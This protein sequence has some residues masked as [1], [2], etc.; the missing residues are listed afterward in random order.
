MVQSDAKTAGWKVDESGMEGKTEQELAQKHREDLQRLQGFRLLDD[1]FMGK[2]F[3]DKDC[4]QLLLQII[5]DRDDLTVQSA[6]GQHEIK[7]LQGRSVRL[8]I[9]AVD[10]AGRIY[11]IE[12][13]R[14]DR[15]AGVKRARYNSSLIDANITAPGDGYEKLNETYV[16]FITER[17]VLQAGLPIYH[18]ERTVRETGA[19]FGDGAH[20]IY[21]NSQIKNATRLGKLM[22]D[23]SCTSAGDMYY[24]I[25]AD[26]VR[27]FKENGKG[28]A[29]MCK[30][31][32]D[33]RSEAARE[34][35]H[36]RSVEN[37]RRMLASGKLTDADIA[38]FSG[39]TLE[40]VKALAKDKTA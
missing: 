33:M 34:A 5:L 18:I 31:M 32:E 9:L 16:I 30:V 40:E 35:A 8:D 1:D 11:N 12:I 15:G 2:V 20:I 3:E 21:V 39:L 6:H 24:N 23:F 14:D 13:Q 4:A 7:N 27:Y 36:A 17:D 25:L 10:A 19:A 38:E 22:H 29:A 26:R 37:A 28:V